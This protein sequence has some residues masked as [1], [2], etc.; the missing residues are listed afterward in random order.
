[1]VYMYIY[2]YIC[3]WFYFFIFLKYIYIY[4]YCY[5][6]LVT[7]MINLISFLRVTARR[8][9]SGHSPCGTELPLEALRICSL[10]CR[11]AIELRLVYSFDD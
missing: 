3:S 4:M 6:G 1:M 8:Q 7:F 2:V 10:L 5:I 11:L 9:L